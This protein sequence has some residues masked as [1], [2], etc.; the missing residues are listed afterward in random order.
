MLS[1]PKKQPKKKSKEIKKSGRGGARPGAGRKSK[2]AAASPAVSAGGPQAVPVLN[3]SD[4]LFNALPL[5]QRCFIVNYLINGFNATKAAIDA[6]F[7]KKTA[8]SQGSRLLKNAKVAAVIAARTMPV[9]EKK[10]LTA[11]RVIDELEKLAFFD[12]RRFWRPD[13]SLVPI[14]ELDDECGAA[15]TGMDVKELYA[16]KCPVGQLKK[17]KYADK[18]VA[19]V[20]LGRYFKLFTDK[21]EHKVK[22]E[23]VVV[24]EALKEPRKLP[25]AKPEFD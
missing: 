23:R 10:A 1:S 5:K 6:G 24:R 8:D 13:G 22:I 14:H 12:P 15:L 19:L 9:F 18:N 3:N 4:A 2:G 17:I 21:V 11:Q 16:D 25:P 20:S 7:S